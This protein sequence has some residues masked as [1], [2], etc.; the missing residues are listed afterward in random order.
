MIIIDKLSK[1]YNGVLA[2][3]QVSLQLNN[4]EIFG[5]VGPNGAGKSTT[6]KALLNYILPDTGNATIDGLDIVKDNKAIKKLVGYVSSEVNFYPEFTALEVIE[7]AMR[8]HGVSDKNKLNHFID[9]F[10]IEKD[11]KIK[12]L[13]LGNK[14]KV[15]IVSALVLNTPILILD[16]PTSGLDPL[17]QNVLF[18][19]L[20]V[21]AKEGKTIFISSHNLKEVQ[22][23]CDRVAFIKAG[24]IIHVVK[25][26]DKLK[27]GKYVRVKGDTK[28][29]ENLD[30]VILMEKENEI[31]FVFTKDLSI[32]IEVLSKM[33][34]ENLIIENL[35]LEHQ[36]LQY[37]SE[38]EIK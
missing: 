15:S 6:I 31:S 30:K 13:S 5:F 9:L 16:E 3:N 37:Y 20:K 27:E 29:L 33:T 35:S 28:K 32:L 34:I 36:F 10:S 24:K 8:M 1:S 23:H 4:G 7:L 18:D 17:M 22:D 11:K 26:S 14:K 2:I 21:M 25:I 38:G 19:Q 12:N